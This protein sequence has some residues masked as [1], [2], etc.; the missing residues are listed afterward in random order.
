MRSKTKRRVAVVGGARIVTTL[1]SE[2][3]SHGLIGIPGMPQS[4]QKYVL[5]PM[6]PFL[7]V[8]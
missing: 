7:A 3:C 1:A 6:A 4:L 8:P 5:I 2:A